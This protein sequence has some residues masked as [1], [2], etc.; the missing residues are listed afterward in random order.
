VVTKDVNDLHVV[1]GNPAR[2]IRI[3]EVGVSAETPP[4]NAKKRRTA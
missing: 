1:A 4:R 3:L 2:V